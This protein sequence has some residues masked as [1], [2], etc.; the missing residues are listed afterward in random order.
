M[1]AGNAIGA[2]SLPSHISS[3]FY[4]RNE[5][6]PVGVFLFP[7]FLSY[8]V[9]IA[10][11][12]SEFRSIHIQA[13]STSVNC[14]RFHLTLTAPTSII[15]DYIS[16]NSNQLDWFCL[17]IGKVFWSRLNRLNSIGTS[18][19]LRQFSE[20][21]SNL[22]KTMMVFSDNNRINVKLNGTWPRAAPT[23]QT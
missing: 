2:A 13:R 16:F 15:V 5:S 4:S 20:S 6:N 10:F 14:D 21:N 19:V 9:A 3:L 17:L 18:C 1:D 23:E 7:F 22:S 8:C 12:S 11:G